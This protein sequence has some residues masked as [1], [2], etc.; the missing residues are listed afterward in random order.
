[1]TNPNNSEH[2]GVMNPPFVAN[3]EAT[4]ATGYYGTGMLSLW[5]NADKLGPYNDAAARHQFK[6]SR[7]HRS[8]DFCG[9][10]HDV[11]NPAVGDLAHNNG[12][13]ATGDPVVASS[14]NPRFDAMTRPL[15]R[16]SARR[17]PN[18]AI[19]TPPSTT[20]SID[21]GRP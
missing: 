19:T 4:P 21:T 14:A 5:G 9:S 7:F 2:L 11:S 1:M 12:K 17:N 18:L 13:Q 20:P 3:D 8:Q 16:N 6:Q 15:P 10:C